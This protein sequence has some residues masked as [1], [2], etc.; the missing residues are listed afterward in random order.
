[1]QSMPASISPGQHVLAEAVGRDPRAVRVRDGDR[2]GE[3]VGRERRRQVA[4]LAVDPVADQLHPAVAALRLQRDVRGEVA[5]L[6]LVGVVADVAPGAGDVAPGAHQPR[7]VVA[8][9]DPRGVDRRAAV[10]QQQRAGVAVGDR[11]LLAG[12]LVDAAVRVEPDVAVRVDQAR[13]DPAARDQL[14]RGDGLVGDAPVDDVQVAALAVGQDRSGEPQRRHAARRY[15]APRRW[16]DRAIGA[17]RFRRC[18]RRRPRRCTGTSPTHGRSRAGPP[19]DHRRRPHDHRHR[20]RDRRPGGRGRDARAELLALRLLDQFSG[21]VELLTVELGRRLGLYAVLA[22]T[23]AVTAAELATARLDRAA[24][25]AGVARPAGRRR[26]R[27]RRRARPV[28]ASGCSRCRRRTRPC[29]STRESPAYLVGAAPLA[30][31]V[32]ASLPGR[33]RRVRHRHRRRVRRLRPRAALRHRRAQPPGLRARHPRLGRAPARRRRPA[34]DRRRD[35]RR[36][37]RR[38]LVEHRPGPRL[39]ARP[40]RGRRPRRRLGEGRARPRRPSRPR[41]PGQRVAGQRRRARPAPRARGRAGD[42][43]DG[44][45]GAARHGRAGAGAGRVPGAARRRRRRAGRRRARQRT[46]RP[47]R[48]TRT[49][50]ASSR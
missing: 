1:M 12:R 26:H 39:P 48:P 23:G 41:G 3:R 40:R 19:D 30:R 24:L 32:A 2:L 47:R 37:V 5:R 21:A 46:P 35:P 44:V 45:P 17:G 18:R 16:P 27:R 43:G 4:G 34:R 9:V 6:D 15:R 28:R 20:D 8:V 31:A 7:Q 11:L 14:G 38:G 29:C 13:H 33:R 50:A 10:A 25:R 42:A 49:S 22:G 36:R